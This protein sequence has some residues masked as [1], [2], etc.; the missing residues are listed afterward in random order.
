MRKIE[1]PINITKIILEYEDGTILSTD[2]QSSPLVG[3]LF[4][5]VATEAKVK[6]KSEGKVSL[7][8]RILN[9]FSI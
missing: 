8:Q 4:F 5:E 9:L 6:W 3:K 1:K 7:K 2:A